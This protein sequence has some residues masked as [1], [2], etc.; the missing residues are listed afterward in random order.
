MVE[1]L[2]RSTKSKNKELK[3]L[4]EQMRAQSLSAT[5]LF[6]DFSMATWA[7]HRQAKILARIDGPIQ[8]PAK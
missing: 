4:Q 2:Y 8:T 1:E 7:I 5:A 6:E 3:Q